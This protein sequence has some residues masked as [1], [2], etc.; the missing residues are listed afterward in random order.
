MQEGITLTIV[1]L[2]NHGFASIGGLSESVGSGGFGTRYRRRGA[3][4]EL[5]G[6]V[7]GGGFRGERRVDGCPRGQGGRPVRRSR[8][9]SPSARGRDGVRSLSCRS[10][11]TQRVGGYESWWDVPVAEVSPLGT[12][13]GRVRS[14]RRDASARAIRS[15]VLC[16]FLR[17]LR[18][19]VLIG[20]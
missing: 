13:S 7:R 20:S 17:V 19:F 4:G 6:A 10:T 9:R 1:L 3:A 14:T 16:S 18:G 8:P 15:S 12:S 2:D 11:A 5:D